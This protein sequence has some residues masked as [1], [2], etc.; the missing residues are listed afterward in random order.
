[1]EAGLEQRGKA[2][3]VLERELALVRAPTA[4][5]EGWWRS[6]AHHPNCP[7]EDERAQRETYSDDF[8]FGEMYWKRRYGGRGITIRSRP[9]QEGPC[10]SIANKSYKRVGP[11][12]DTRNMPA[13]LD[14]N[15][16][17]EQVGAG[18]RSRTCC[19]VRHG[20]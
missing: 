9:L 10:T 12:G 4:P 17:L 8:G 5:R 14:L 20:Q 2:V 13:E 19:K 1:M 18:W 16:D 11:E 7:D 3:T 6:F 15:Y